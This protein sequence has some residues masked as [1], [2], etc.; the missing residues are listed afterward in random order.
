MREHN[1]TNVSIQCSTTSI[2]YMIVIR[3]YYVVHN[4]VTCYITVHVLYTTCNITYTYMMY[5]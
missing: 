5:M 2:T 4:K 1:S 3:L